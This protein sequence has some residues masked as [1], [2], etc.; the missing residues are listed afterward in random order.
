MGREK[1]KVVLGGGG[2]EAALLS[3]RT[4]FKKERKRVDGE[5]VIKGE[6]RRR[7]T[8]FTPSRRRKERGGKRKRNVC[9]RQKECTAEGFDQGMENYVFPKKGILRR[10][11]KATAFFM[12]RQY[13]KGKGWM[14]RGGRRRRK[15]CCYH[16]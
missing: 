3:D 7:E 13:R 9:E 5:W 15:C 14:E 12:R 10:S 16:Q 2:K 8:S 1:H 6:L 4:L 11:V